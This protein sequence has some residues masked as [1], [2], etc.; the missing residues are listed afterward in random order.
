M[1]LTHALNRPEVAQRIEAA[2]A[3]ALAAHPT[4]DLGGQAG[5]QAFTQQVVA[6][7]YKVAA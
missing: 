6:A 1:L 3:A 7:L 2:V 5:T 4:P